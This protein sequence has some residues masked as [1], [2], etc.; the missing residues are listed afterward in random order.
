VFLPFVKPR[1]RYKKIHY[2]SAFL[3]VKNSQ[4]SVHRINNAIYENFKA[5]N[6]LMFRVRIPLVGDWW[7][8]IREDI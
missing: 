2:F 6:S 1:H 3:S 7:G 5:F 4:F 8:I